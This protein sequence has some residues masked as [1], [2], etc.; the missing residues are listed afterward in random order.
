MPQDKR[1]QMQA[2]AREVEGLT[3]SPLYATRQEHGY[4][5]VI[6]DGSLEAAVMFIG[7]APGEQEAKSGRPF[8]GAAGRVLGDLMESIGLRREDVYITNIVKD[9]PPNNRDPRA[10]EIALYAPF[11]WRQVEIIRPRVLVTL[12]RFAMEFVLE[13]LNLPQQGRTIGELHGQVI[14]AEAPFGPLVVVPLYHPASAFYNERL[15]A[16]LE[17]DFQVL[18]PYV[19]R[20]EDQ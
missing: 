4:H 14:P 13:Q 18:A 3:Q 17:E 9:R 11:L 10:D 12:G 5:A 7:E 20:R 2:I 19:A 15:R 8:V 16:T 6:G 1:A